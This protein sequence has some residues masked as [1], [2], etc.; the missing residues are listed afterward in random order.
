[1]ADSSKK[2]GEAAR[3]APLPNPLADRTI[4]I[5]DD[6]PANI[7]HVREGLAGPGY[8]FREAHD[9]TEALR[10]LREARPDLIIMD[11]EMPRL[12]G[13]EVCRIIKANGG[14]GGFG[15]I[16]VI[17]VTARQA[18]GKVEGLELGADD[19]LVKP[20]DMMELSARVK[21][22]LRLK[23]LQDALV[24]KNRE[25]DSKNQALDRAYKELDQK[26]EELL[27]LTRVDGLTGLY[28]RRYFEERLSEEFARSARYRSPLSLVMMDIDHFKRLNDTYGH[29]FGDQV[30]RA[31]AQAVRGRLREVD[32]VARYGGEEF[33]ALLP[34]TGPK[35]ALG[36][37]ERIREAVAS[38][39]LEYQPPSGDA[40]EV[41]CTASLG[42]ASVP[43][44]RLLG[45]ED[46]KKEADTCLYA[47]KA[48]GRNC[49][50]QY[51]D[52]P[53]E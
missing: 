44:Q 9:G 50:R 46:L 14:E 10:S 48:A 20:F 36:A 8:R 23:V 33:I 35:E 6:D 47:A 5:V 39:R 41:R 29:P 13:V 19:Y 51:K 11:V 53:P 32:F 40:L 52:T 22:M 25:L 28:N 16:P 17:L 21:S 7:Q 42:V 24:E 1:M 38:V 15:F 3:R 2:M 37:C 18:A 45:A 31:V 12:G 49:V 4:L 30:L 34:E 26:R 43:S 27:K